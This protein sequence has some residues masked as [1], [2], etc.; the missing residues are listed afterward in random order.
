[1]NLH[2]RSLL[3]TFKMFFVSIILWH[4][5]CDTQQCDLFITAVGVCWTRL[6]FLSTAVEIQCMLMSTRR[7][8]S[9]Q[10]KLYHF[11]HFL[12]FSDFGS[13]ELLSSH[14]FLL[15]NIF[16]FQSSANCLAIWN[17]GLPW[18]W[19]YDSWIYNYLGNQYLSPLTLW[20]QIPLGR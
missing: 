2:L 16:T 18:L 4:W 14:L 6:F 7:C 13:G 11:P 12:F 3:S 15:S 17:Q 10:I 19:S 9:S 1:M 8:L 5:L 20:V